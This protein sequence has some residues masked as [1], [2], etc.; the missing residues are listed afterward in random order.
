MFTKFIVSHNKDGTPTSRAVGVGG[1][2][3]ER[4][5]EKTKNRSKSISIFGGI[6]SVLHFPRYTLTER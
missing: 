3:G 4:V 5:G 6:C 2:V 1:G